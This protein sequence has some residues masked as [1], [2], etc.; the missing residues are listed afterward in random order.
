MKRAHSNKFPG[1][2]RRFIRIHCA[3][4]RPRKL[5]TENG[6]KQCGVHIMQTPSHFYCIN[7]FDALARHMASFCHSSMLFTLLSIS[8]SFV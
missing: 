2:L 4:V 6:W 5:R 8:D 1:V 3:E 7:P